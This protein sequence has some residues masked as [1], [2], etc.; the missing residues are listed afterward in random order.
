MPTER[1]GGSLEEVLG[2]PRTKLRRNA[3]FPG[4]VEHVVL[5]F[6]VVLLGNLAVSPECQGTQLLKAQGS[7]C[8]LTRNIHLANLYSL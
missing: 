8:W 1:P 6:R 4:S 3:W 7:V 5:A 2:Y